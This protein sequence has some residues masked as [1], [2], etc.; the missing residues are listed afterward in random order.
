MEGQHGNE[1]EQ[2]WLP[3]VQVATQAP[4]VHAVSAAQTLQ[5]AP[6]WPQSASVVPSWHAPL[7]QHPVQDTESQTHW[8]AEHLRPAPHVPP[9][10]TVRRWPQAS[11]AVTG[12]HATGWA[13]QNAASVWGQTH[14]PSLQDCPGPSLSQAW[15][16]A[17]ALSTTPSQSSSL[18]L[19]LSTAGAHW[20]TL[21][22]TPVSGL[23]CQ[24]GTHW[25]AEVQ[26]TVQ[27]YLPLPSGR[28]RPLAQSEF[29]V[30]AWPESA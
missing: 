3:S 9:Q 23:H 6:P 25:E 8:L 2:A 17:G 26:G 13:V 27:A 7:E 4:A 24:P 14:L 18:A 22:G 12:P 11:V 16:T 15:S 29:F 20:Q 28:Q 5:T 21:P 30:H 10:S 1:A 19:Q